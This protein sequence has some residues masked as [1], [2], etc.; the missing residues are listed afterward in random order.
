MVS[1][2]IKSHALDTLLPWAWK[3]EQLPATAHA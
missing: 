2:R 3:A 1:G